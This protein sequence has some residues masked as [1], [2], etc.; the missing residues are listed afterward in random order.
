M[1]TRTLI[2]I[3]TVLFLTIFSMLILI[4]S[5]DVGEEEFVV[6]DDILE[7]LESDLVLAECADMFDQTKQEFYHSLEGYTCD[8]PICPETEP[9]LFSSV[10]NSDEEFIEKECAKFVDEWAYLTEDN[11]Y[12]WNSVNWES[13]VKHHYQ[14]DPILDPLRNEKCAELFDLIMLSGED[15]DL[16]YELTETNDFRDA[17]C[18]S[19]VSEWEPLTEYD[20]WNIGVSWD[21]VEENALYGCDQN[22]VYFSG[23][24][25]TLETKQRA[26]SIGELENEK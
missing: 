10:L 1:K 6:T 25:M 21:S 20:V 19:I 8:N 11:D 16:W 12:T 18:A 3:P 2:L 5:N 13:F 14:S 22:E 15:S 26:Q 23:V 9:P 24:C 4:F 7:A 17:K